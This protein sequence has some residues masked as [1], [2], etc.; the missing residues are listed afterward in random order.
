MSKTQ[1]REAKRL[2]PILFQARR[3]GQFL[4]YA[5]AAARL[6]RSSR[7]NARMAAQV[8]DLLDAAAGLAGVP[9]LAL[10][11]VLLS[12]RQKNHKA[13]KGHP[14]R[15][16]IIERSRNHNFRDSDVA[17]IGEALTQ[18]GGMGNVAAWK[19]LRARVP[20][21]KLSQSLAE[22]IS[23]ADFDAI[24]DLGSDFPKSTAAIARGFLRDPQIRRAVLKRAKGTCELCGKV[25]F[26]CSDGSRY[27]ESH[28]IIALADDG[29]DRMSNV[30]ALCADDRREAHF[31]RRRSEL[32]ARMIGIVRE[33]SG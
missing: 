20:S 17:S 13:F 15:A 3:S 11:T 22:L 24:N 26:L 30:I 8:C 4:T 33:L 2:L 14:L 23:L 27:L 16:A 10:T 21:G 7:D 28:H 31:G 1:H 19:W 29:P 18:L 25:G 32:E 6:G 9:P 5:S 12:S